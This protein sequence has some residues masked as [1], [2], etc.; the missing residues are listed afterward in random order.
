MN[1]VL[2]VTMLWWHLEGAPQVI[3]LNNDGAW[4]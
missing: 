3:N 2:K 1:E 4:W